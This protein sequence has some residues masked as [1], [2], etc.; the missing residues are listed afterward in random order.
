[1]SKWILYSFTGTY[2]KFFAPLRESGKR[3]IFTSDANYSSFIDDI[4]AAGAHCF[5][6]EPTTDMAYVAEKYGRTHGFVGNAGTR[7]LL[8]GTRAQIRTEVERCMAIG[9]HCPGFFM[10]VGNHIPANTPVENALY[11]NEV[12]EELSLR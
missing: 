6:M 5:V 2:R 8:F 10:A 7:I 9:K 3:I 4:A 11:Y 1:M 12:Y